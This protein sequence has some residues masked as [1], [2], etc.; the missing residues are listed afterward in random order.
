MQVMSVR[1]NEKDPKIRETWKRL[2]PLMEKLG[3]VDEAKQMKAEGARSRIG[4]L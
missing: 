2:L 1:E 4:F 3:L